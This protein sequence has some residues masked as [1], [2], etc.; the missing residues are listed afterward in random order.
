MGLLQQWFV[1]PVLFCLKIDAHYKYSC[2]ALEVLSLQKSYME[3]IILFVYIYA[4]L[5][6]V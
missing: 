4:F 1:V 5:L 3:I 2:T 6:Y